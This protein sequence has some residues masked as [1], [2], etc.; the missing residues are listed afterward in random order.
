LTKIGRFLAKTVRKS[1]RWF[2]KKPVD[3]SAKPTDLSVKLTDLLV[4][5]VFTV[6][7]SSPLRFDRIFL[8]FAKFYRFFKKPTGSV[9]SDF[10]SFAEFLN[11]GPRC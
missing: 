9:T 3:L 11:I 4:F 7:P 6:P 1:P 10:R 8:I 5:L 2:S